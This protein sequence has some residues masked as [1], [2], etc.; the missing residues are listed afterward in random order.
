MLTKGERVVPKDKN[1]E[2]WDWYEAIDNGTLL[3]KVKT[4]KLMPSPRMVNIPRIDN[5]ATNA[6][7][8]K[9]ITNNVSVEVSALKK[10]I[11]ELKN[12]MLLVEK[13]II[14]K[15]TT[16]FN[17]DKNGIHSI[18]ESINKSNYLRNRL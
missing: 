4:M 6:V 3:D 7:L 11:G 12:T 10:E 14:E 9:A 13:A 18:S 2:Y 8:Q 5:N 16:K 17:I 15:P 1:K